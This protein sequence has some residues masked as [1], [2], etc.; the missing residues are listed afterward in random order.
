MPEM[1]AGIKG[2]RGRPD[3]KAQSLPGAGRKRGVHPFLAFLLMTSASS[4][5][6]LMLVGHPPIYGALA[7]ATYVVLIASADRPLIVF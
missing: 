1:A 5:R 3:G 6:P 7:T 4:L 2:C